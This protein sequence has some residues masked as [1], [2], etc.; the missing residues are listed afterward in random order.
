MPVVPVVHANPAV[1]VAIRRGFPRRG[2]RVR[3]IADLAAVRAL[4][5]RELV[6]AVV[7]DVKAGDPAPTFTLAAEFPT[8]PVWAF[9]AFRPDDG[10]LLAACLEG[11]LRGVFVEGVDEAA[12]GEV[13]AQH[14]ASRAR[15]AALGDAPRQLRLT[16]DIQRAAFFEVFA[17]AGI[18]TT[19][20]DVA[21]ALERTREHLS[22]EFAAGGAPNLKR[23]IDLA[24]AVCAAD[25]LQNPGY[26]VRGVAAVLQYASPSHLATATRRVAGATPSE[27]ARL[28]PKGVFQRFLRGRTRSRI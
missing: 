27:L 22:R 25:L 16:E 3:R 19:T 15:L 17:R 28:G 5:A 6:D 24:R 7:V 8:I 18:R 23:V 10:V 14:T 11:G 21:D 13:I 2:I 12:A 26:D 9:S 1:R 20:A 4:L